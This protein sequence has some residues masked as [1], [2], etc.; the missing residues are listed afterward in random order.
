MLE[1]RGG[2]RCCK[3]QICKKLIKSPSR[4]RTCTN[5]PRQTTS[6]RC[7]SLT[8][9]PISPNLETNKKSRP[10]PP[11]PSRVPHQLHRVTSA[12]PR[13]NLGTQRDATRY[14]STQRPLFLLHLHEKPSFDA[15]W[16]CQST[17][18]WR[19]FFFFGEMVKKLSW[20]FC[21]ICMYSR[22]VNL[23]REITTGSEINYRLLK[24]SLSLFR[25]LDIY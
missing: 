19:S 7:Q 18:Y 8:K 24:I 17:F 12:A 15:L 1:A 11:P 4:G 2:R 6:I 13:L 20:R 16:S 10:M 14:N 3:L 5:P 22:N 21:R 9:L 25:K 23:T